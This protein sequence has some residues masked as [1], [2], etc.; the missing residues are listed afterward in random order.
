[1]SD[2]HSRD[3]LAPLTKGQVCEILAVSLPTLNR[4]VAAGE[5]RVV[6]VGV[7]K[8]SP[9]ITRDD[10]AAYLDGAAVRADDDDEAAR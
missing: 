9:R 2:R 3:P 4:I 8:G 6:Y 5:L 10:L 7:G 1:M